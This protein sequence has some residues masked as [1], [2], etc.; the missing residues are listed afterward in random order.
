M[1]EVSGFT[2]P[3]SMAKAGDTVRVVRVRG[4]EELK[5]HLSN[6][7]FVEGSEVHV[8]NQALGN[9][10]VMVKGSRL[11]IDSKTA[12]RVMVA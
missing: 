1:A 6:L 4:G 5:R 3:L 12:M 10:I 11:G 9:I 7:G 8:V 2:M